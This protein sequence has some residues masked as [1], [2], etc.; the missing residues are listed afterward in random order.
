MITAFDDYSIHQTAEPIAHPVS[1]DRNH[2]DRYWFNGLDAGGAFTFECGFGL[3]PNR[4]VMDGHFSLVHDGRQH[5]FH[6]SGR[7]PIDRTQTVIGPLQV[8]VEEPMRRVRLRL[9]PNE[10]GLACNLV[11]SACTAPTEEPKNLLRNGLR[12]VMHN[13]RFT[14]F[15][16][17]SGW[18][19]VDGQRIQISPATTYGTRDKSWGVR[20]LGEPEGGG[21]G[22]PDAEPGVYWCWSPVNFGGTCTLFGTFE[23][24]DGQP[25]QLSGCIVPTYRDA[26][27]TPT[28]SV[29]STEEEMATVRHDI[30]WTP[31]TRYPK[32]ATVVFVSK[33]GTERLVRLRSLL[34]FYM[35]GIGYQHPEWSHGVWQG[36]EKFGY[37]S[38]S[39]DE[40]DPLDRHNVHVH[41]VVAA[42]M[43]G[44][45]G[46]G[47]METVMLGRHSRSGFK[48]FLDGAGA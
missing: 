7:C 19:E 5:S 28:E 10:H 31:G 22:D 15:G 26:G 25:T 29:P 13:S 3:Y 45:T 11:F 30:E 17:W 44:R 32:S 43:D 6:A 14:Q 39:L 41:H 8:A 12:V 42:D 40:L 36:E 20:P 1:G 38:W 9:G 16:Y 23:D 18:Y 33:D 24:H 27:S 48:D 2:Y 46:A 37:D 4:F 35:R 47:I 34:R 21:A